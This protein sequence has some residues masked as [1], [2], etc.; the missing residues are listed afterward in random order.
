MPYRLGDVNGDGKVTVSD[1]TL[2][3]MYVAGG[4][5]TDPQRVKLCGKILQ[6][7]AFDGEI[8][9]NDATEIQRYLAEFGTD[10]P[11]GT[12]IESY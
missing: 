3:Q 6:R 8:T 5:M 4:V 1:V 12:E 10:H 7:G 2:L 9:I 11:I